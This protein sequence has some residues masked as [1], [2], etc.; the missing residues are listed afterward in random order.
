MKLAFKRVEKPFHFEVENEAGAQLTIDAAKNIGGTDKGLRPM[1]L[2][3]AGVAGCI[4]IDLTLI[5]EKQ[6]IDS[7]KFNIEIEANRVEGTPSPFENIHLKFE[8]APEIDTNRLTKN[9][10]LVIDKYCSVSASLKESIDIT[11]EIIQNETI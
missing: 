6:R 5:L 1:E 3:A 11:F 9:I 2:V 8:L 4:A 7:D 10:Q